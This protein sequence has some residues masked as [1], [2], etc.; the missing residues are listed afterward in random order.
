VGRLAGRLRALRTPLVLVGILVVVGAANQSLAI[1]PTDPSIW[2]RYATTGLVLGFLYA[3]VAVGYSIVYGVLRLLNFAHGEVF[4]VGSF[5][6]LY[7]LHLLLNSGLDVPIAVFLAM[8]AGAG[9]S[10]LVAITVERV[11]YRPLR[12]RGAS[13]LGYLITA[14]GVSLILQNLFLLSDGQQHLGFTWPRIAGAGV[15]NYPPAIDVVTVFQLVNAPVTNRQL[16]VIGVSIIALVAAEVVVNR[17]RYGRRIRAVAEDP[18]TASL[19]GIDVDRSIITTFLIGGLLAGIA[20]VLFGLYYSQ[21]QFNMGFLL[22]IKA[23][24]AAV[25]GGIGN[26]RGAVLGGIALG[27]IENLGASCMGIQWQ[28]VIVFLLL[29]IVLMFRPHGLL[30]EQV[31]DD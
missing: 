26:L 10:A 16:L 4:M 30:G 21:A 13:R 25:L 12:V 28:P 11:A 29:G 7:S 22:G 19:M 3:L 24:T 15:V 23:F 1:C 17:T 27:L 31:R 18:D 9:G 6:G 14:I 8:A 2:M 5:A 20:G